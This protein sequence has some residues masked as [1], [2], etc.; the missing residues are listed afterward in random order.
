M[1]CCAVALAALKL[2]QPHHPILAYVSPSPLFPLPSLPNVPWLKQAVRS[3]LVHSWW[4]PQLV[5]V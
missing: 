2:N 4:R 1:S 3:W 5:N